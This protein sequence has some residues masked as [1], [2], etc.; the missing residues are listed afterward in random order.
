MDL[1]AALEALTMKSTERSWGIK[2]R[3]RKRISLMNC[4][5]TWKLIRR[6]FRAYHQNLS[7]KVEET[8]RQNNIR[9]LY[10]FSPIKDKVDQPVM[11]CKE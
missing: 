2:T 1:N 6:N 5:F 4:I 3:E 7:G 11:N 8:V 9:R 10:G